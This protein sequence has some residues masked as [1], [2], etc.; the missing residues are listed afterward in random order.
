MELN[1]KLQMLRKQKGMTQEELAGK[2]YVSRTAISK[3][4]SG[5]GIPN[6][7]SLKAL[8]KFFS[9]SLDDLL[10][11]DEL[12]AIAE[13]DHREKEGRTLDW[14]LGLLDASML[15][16]LFLPFFGEKTEDAIRAVSLSQLKMIQPNIRF[17]CLAGVIAAALL[18]AI[19]IVLAKKEWN[20]WG[21]NK[22]TLSIGFGTALVM[23]F[24]LI[25]QPYAAAF[26]FIFLMIK[27]VMLF[28]M[29]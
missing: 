3:W 25:R 16:L 23:L 1:E 28:K 19:R 2:L 13:K 9:V 4:E 17:F 10:S 14:M 15:L 26:S 21:R 11:G 22:N 18:G 12:L 27:G 24:I 8:S 20:W 6:L 7:D 5:R 29:R